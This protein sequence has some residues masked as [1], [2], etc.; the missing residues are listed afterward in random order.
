METPQT[1]NQ[2]KRRS[3]PNR[4][5]IALVAAAMFAVTVA[6][7]Y[8][9]ENWRG[10]RAWDAYNEELR[11]KGKALDWRAHIPRE[12]PD[13]QNIFKAPELKGFTKG[14]GSSPFLD[15]LEAVNSEA[16]KALSNGVAVATL[17]IVAP[18]STR[19]GTAIAGSLSEAAVRIERIPRQEVSGAMGYLFV[20]DAPE[21]VAFHSAAT[22]TMEHLQKALPKFSIQPAG[23]NLFRVSLPEAISAR[24]YLEAT[25]ALDGDLENLRRALQRPHSRMD[26]DYEKPHLIPVP[27][28]VAVR[29]LAQTLGQRA[30]CFLLLHQPDQ[31]LA[32]VELIAAL[33]GILV[34]QPDRK[35]MTLVA[36]MI[37]VAIKGLHI[38]VIQD[39]LRFGAWQESHL[40][41]LQAQ[42]SAIDLLPLVKHSLELE[43]QAISHIA[44]TIPLS[45]VFQLGNEKKRAFDMFRLIPQGWVYRNVIAYGRTMEVQAHVVESEL[46]FIAP[47]KIDRGFEAVSSSLEGRSPFMYLAQ[48]AIPNFGKAIRTASRNQTKAHLALVACALERHLLARGN[49]PERLGELVPQFLPAIPRDT[50]LGGELKYRRTEGRKYLLYS[51]GWNETDDGGVPGPEYEKGDWVWSANL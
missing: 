31:A 13:E 33:S 42:L 27:N 16:R 43:R 23:S 20:A 9:V 36:A 51:I 48:M 21:H 6:L 46:P 34:P 11:G 19:A 28:F 32:Q 41:A 50:I 12:V 29:T 7:F 25:K 22:I 49:Y 14:N 24:T 17:E 3:A 35:A 5:Q 1:S 15:R 38:A 2:Q 26:G 8:V 18:G 47:R 37:E 39:G 30:Q 45:D 44:L 40:I 10:S 4:L